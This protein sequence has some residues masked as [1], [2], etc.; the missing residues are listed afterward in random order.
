MD[1][2]RIRKFLHNSACKP[3]NERKLTSD[4]DFLSPRNL[5]SSFAFSPENAVSPLID[6][7]TIQLLRDAQSDPR[8]TP[9]S[10]SLDTH[11]L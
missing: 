7:K 6:H 4:T 5:K 11:S 3:L 9:L 2:H 1:V 8:E 10:L